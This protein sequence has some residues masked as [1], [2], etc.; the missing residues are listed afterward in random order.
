MFIKVINVGSDTFGNPIFHEGLQ[1]YRIGLP[2]VSLPTLM[3]FNVPPFALRPAEWV[4]KPGKIG[5]VKYGRPLV[6]PKQ[7]EEIN[8]VVRPEENIN[9]DKDC[10]VG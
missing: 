9:H 3:T 5:D 6:F 2:K 10:T 7:H 1:N 8:V 4:K